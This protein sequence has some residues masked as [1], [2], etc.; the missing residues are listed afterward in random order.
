MSAPVWALAALICWCACVDSNGEQ[1]NIDRSGVNSGSAPYPRQNS[2]I[3]FLPDS[4]G[5]SR[6]VMP[7]LI[8]V[9]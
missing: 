2:L 7:R 1:P 5:K 4:E 8:G 9:N 6:L 3:D